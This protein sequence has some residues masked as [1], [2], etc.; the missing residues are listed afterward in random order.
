MEM[1]K[2]MEVVEVKVK[3]D[4]GEGEVKVE[5]VKSP[6]GVNDDQSRK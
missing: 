1:M 5:K 4:G 6:R 3:G 2:V